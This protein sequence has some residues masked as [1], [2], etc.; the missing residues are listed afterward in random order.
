MIET[1]GELIA[2]FSS[3]VWGLP[4]VGLILGGGIF[5]TIYSRFAPLRHLFHTLDVLR[6]KYSSPDDPGQITHF[7]A[8]CTALASTIGLGNISGVAIAIFQGG[9]GALFWMWLCAAL[10]MSTK[11]FTCT[12][13]VL[14]RGRDSAGELQGGPMYFIQE[15][16]G[17][18]FKPLAV[19]F[20]VCGLLGCLSLFQTNQLMEIFLSQP[21]LAEWSYDGKLIFRWVGGILVASLVGMVIFGGIQRIGKVTSKLTPAMALMY[22]G[23]CLVILIMNIQQVP[24]AFLSIFEQAFNPDAAFGGALGAVILVGVRRGAFSNEAGIGTEALAHGAAKTKEPIREGLVAMLGPLIDTLVIC[25]MTG[26]VILVTGVASEAD[27][28]GVAM[29]SRA[30]ETALP[31]VGAGAL[32]VCVLFFS[33]STMIGYSYYGAKCSGFLFGAASKNRYNAFYLFMLVVGAVASSSMVVNFVDG[34]FA[35]MAIPTMFGTL[36]LAPRVMKEARAY[37][38]KI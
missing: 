15:G 32:L 7:Q 4:L 14:Y 24:V 19:F 12:L 17:P 33:V 9:P 10:G 34:M 16:L 11:F 3:L 35:L 29:T 20:A 21:A 5:F 13:S 27:Q 36:A 25:T 22:V 23:L 1:I 2:S 18:K 26:L 28:G 6:G 8:L 31:G 30:F 38:D 37:F